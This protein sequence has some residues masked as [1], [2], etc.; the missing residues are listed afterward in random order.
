MADRQVTQPKPLGKCT[1]DGCGRAASR[2]GAR[3]CEMH[4]YRMRRR[5]RLTTLAEETGQRPDL[6]HSHGYVLEH[7]PHHPLATKR[8]KSRIYQHRLRYYEAYGDGPFAC[9]WCGCEVG[10]SDMHVDHLNDV[11][12][13][14]RLANLV[15]SCAICNQ[16]RA[17]GRA[18]AGTRARAKHVYELNGER[19]TAGQWASKI[20]ISRV[21]LMSRIEKGWSLEQAL[22]QGRGKTGPQAKNRPPR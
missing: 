4:Y 1:A 14:N 17:K 10:W 16:G 19:L 13:D 8:Q 2:G 9:H 20:G 22:T 3:L 15:A 12:S 6:R 21:S 7:A 5:G 18:A 11:K